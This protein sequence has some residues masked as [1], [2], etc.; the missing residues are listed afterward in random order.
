MPTK[1]F[2]F[3]IGRSSATW[4]ATMDRS[5]D[6]DRSCQFALAS[7]LLRPAR[8]NGGMIVQSYGLWVRVC[9]LLRMA[10][11]VDSPSRAHR[12]LT[13]GLTPRRSH[14]FKPQAQRSPLPPPRHPPAS[15]AHWLTSAKS[16]KRKREAA[17]MDGTRGRWWIEFSIGY[18]VRVVCLL[19]FR[20]LDT[21]FRTLCSCYPPTRRT[22]AHRTT[23]YRAGT[24]LAKR[25]RRDVRA[26]R[27][28]LQRRCFLDGGISIFGVR[29]T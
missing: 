1:K 14:D 6:S 20:E 19:R 21:A 26:R 24:I 10:L 8:T 9:F 27:P 4:P 23:I 12:S 17:R 25:G 29:S 28:K 5:P 7:I 11:R 3:T 13:E 2:C 22:P 15:A 16:L 18:I